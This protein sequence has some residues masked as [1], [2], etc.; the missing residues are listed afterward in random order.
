MFS[1]SSSVLH[2]ISMSVHQGKVILFLKK[3][4]KNGENVLT[5]KEKNW[6]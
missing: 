4:I 3:N 2:K 5:V 1:V 6:G